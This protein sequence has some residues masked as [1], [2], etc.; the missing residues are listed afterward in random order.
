[1]C[2]SYLYQ[3]LKQNTTLAVTLSTIWM[4]VLTNL[5]E[6]Y[7]EGYDKQTT[8][9]NGPVHLPSTQL[10]NHLTHPS[11]SGG[12]L[13]FLVLRRS[14]FHGARYGPVVAG[15]GSY[16]T[17]SRVATP[18]CSGVTWAVRWCLSTNSGGSVDCHILSATGR[19]A[20]G[21]HTCT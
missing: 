11:K 13:P 14:S 12:R 16:I 6:I 18:D 20:D 8:N 19:P 10:L 17:M 3:C 7:F 1:M 9:I 5:A 4:V 2:R 21:L 15:G